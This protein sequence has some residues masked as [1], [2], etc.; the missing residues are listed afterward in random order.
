[1]KWPAL[2]L[3]LCLFSSN[4]NAFDY[5]KTDL[6]NFYE[7]Y[8]TEEKELLHEVHLT[9]DTEYVP[10][11][12]P[13]P[14]PS[15]SPTPSPSPS[16]S[17]SPT[18]APTP[19][20]ATPPAPILNY[21]P[22]VFINN[23]GISADRIYFLGTG[24]NLSGTIAHFMEPDLST[25]ICSFASPAV[26]NS[27][28]ANISVKL[29]E[30]PSAGENS[31]LIYVPQ[32]I[33]GRC[34]LSIDSPLYLLTTDTTISA[35][36][37]TSPRDPTYYTL[38]QN[39]ELTLD[40]G[41]NLY[42]NVSNVDFYSLPMGIYSRTYPSGDAYPTVDNLI[43][44]GFSVDTSRQSILTSVG[45]AL[46][47][48]DL[49]TTAQWSK[50][51]IPFYSN[52]YVTPASPLTDLRILA[53]KL[54]IGFETGGFTGAAYPQEAFNSNYLQTPL[55]GPI[56]GKSYMTA[57]GEYY[58][59][60]NHLLL[61][62]FPANQAEATYLMTGQSDTVL[63]LTAVSGTG[64]TDLT[65][66]LSNLTTLD[67]LGGAVGSWDADSV[68]TPSGVTV[69]N[70]EIAKLLSALFTIGQFPPRSTLPQPIIDSDS[71]YFVNYRDTYFQNPT[72]FSEHGPWY[73]LFDQAMH[74]LMMKTDGYG[75]GYAFDYDDLIG[76]GGEMQVNIQT[77]GVLNPS[78]P[79]YEITLGP[80]DTSIPDP[81]ASFGPYSLTVN[82]ILNTS[83]AID[84]LYS[85]T[86]GGN[87]TNILHVPQN[88]VAANI[89]TV[90]DYFLVRYNLSTTQE[91]YKVYPL[92]QLV[93]PVTT[94]YKADD[95]LKMDGI[96]FVSVGGE[97]T[98]FTISLPN[99]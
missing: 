83:E 84:I 15:P 58:N 40:S 23:S 8:L 32:Q 63:S 94:T 52:P 53:A 12:I 67:L 33:S 6:V 73:N 16:P 24:K 19:T 96:S 85:T 30:L 47:N 35:P 36:S 3:S 62:I 82:P 4:A 9:S 29:S 70:T 87:P 88:G 50:L 18:P 14:S 48:S 92:H 72:G 27:A 78:N 95:T 38:Y 97:G 64:A 66:N 17:P 81:T 34:Y 99:L 77:S 79:Y 10:T 44:S 65:I 37:V 13:P 54:S 11:P 69:W 28:D 25:G 74:P 1:M 49:S 43:S 98:S 42:S 91:T 39:F 2:F 41:Y 59:E 71:L 5:S 89:P 75:L 7:N 57:L 22:V 56:T 31:Y 93:L 55:S 46:V 86:S 21:A 61:K 76:L 26:S 68:F 45:N 90:Y 60:P 51:T 80:V 20:P